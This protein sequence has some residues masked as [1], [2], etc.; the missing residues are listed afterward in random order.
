MSSARSTTSIDSNRVVAPPH[1]AP[2]REGDPDVSATRT[3]LAE[4]TTN[5][6]QT[7]T[8]MIS[9]GHLVAKAL[10]AEGIDVIYT[11][12]GGHIIA[13]YHGWVDEG[14]KGL[15]VP[16]E[17]VAPPAAHPHARVTSKPGRAGGTPRPGTTH[18]LTR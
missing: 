11:L 14:T 6:Q 3:P 1:G 8:Q 18:P 13:I 5:G 12:C 9:G 4:E 16:P 2:D 7:E 17:Q 15:D 10:K